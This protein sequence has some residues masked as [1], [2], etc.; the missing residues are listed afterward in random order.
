MLS[1]L[2]VKKPMTVFVAVVLIIVLG[3]VSYMNMT[4]DLLPDFEM[5]YVVIMTTYPGQS[6]EAVEKTVTKPLEASMST[7]ENISNVTS[8]SAEN[9]SMLMLEFEDGT[10]MDSVTVDIRGKID[11]LKGSWPDEVGTPSLL[12]INP[13]IMPVAVAAVNYE[14]KSRAELSYYLENTLQNKLEGINGVASINAMGVLEE[15]ENVVISQEKLDKLNKKIED[16]LNDK[17]GEAE[18]KLNEAKQTLAD[19]IEKAESGAGQIDDAKNALSE[20]QQEVS[21][22]LANA[23]GEL[24]SKQMELLQTKL[25]LLNKEET[26]LSQKQQLQTVYEQLVKLSDSYNKLSEQKEQLTE[27]SA[28]LNMLNEQYQKLVDELAKYEPGTEDYNR[29]VSQL[30][31]IDQKLK[32]FGFT[33]AELPQRAAEA[34]ASLDKVVNSIETIKS[35]IQSMGYS[36]DTFFNET[37]PQMKDSIDKIDEGVA[38]IEDGL[39]QLES[40]EATVSSAIS[41][42][43]AQESAANFQINTAM[44][45]IISN[46]ATLNM[47]LTQLDSAQ[48]EIDT[49]M[50]ELQT[51]K[52]QAKEAADVNKTVTMDNISKILSAQNFSMPAG[53]ITDDNNQK[54]MVR[55]GDTVKDE[56]ELND[57]VLIDIGLD[58]IDPIKVSDVADVFVVDNS[59]EIYAKING[60]NGLL[61]SF[62]KQSNYATAEV[63]D[64]ILAKFEELEKEN[65]GL[66]FTTLMNQ[67][68]YIYMITNSVLQNLLYGALLAIIILFLFLRDIK[69]TVVIACSIPISV[70]FAIVLMYFSGVTLNMI[71]LS[72]LAI[73]VGMLVDNSVVVIENIYRLRN[74]GIPP[75]KAAMNGAKQ[76]A[77]AITA[78]TLTTVCVFLPIVFVEGLTRQLF[79]DMALTIGYSLLASLI[80]ALTLVPAMGQRLFKNTKPRSHKIFDKLITYYEKSLRFTLRHRAIALIVA[81]V[82]LAGSMM[83]SFSKGFSFLPD[84]SSSEISISADLPA[85]NTFEDTA[86]VAQ[87]ME[88][89]LQNDFDCFDTVGVLVGN[90]SSIIGMSSG[91]TDTSSITAYCVLKESEAKNSLNIIKQVQ[92]KLDT[93]DCEVEVGGSSSMSSIGSL[94]GSGV[95][96]KLYGDDLDTLKTT[97]QDMADKLSEIEG[98]DTVDSGIEATTPEIKITVDKEKAVLKNL[99]VAQVY[100][101]VAA[102]LSTEKTATGLTNDNGSDLDV[103]VVDTTE[104]SK[105]IDDIKNIKITYTTTEGDE[106][107]VK[108]SEI[109]DITT[110]ESMNSIKHDN[111]VRYVT[112]SG[113]IKDGYTTTAVTNQVEKYFNSYDL[114]NGFSIEYAGE[115]S[116]TMEAL[117]QLMLMMLLGVIMIY[118][119][120]V[121]QFQSLKSPFIVMFTI[122]LA[123]TG[124]FLGLIVTGY[125]VSVV[126]M[127]GFIMLFGIIVNNG[128]VLVD[129]VNQLRL[130]GMEK[131]QALIDAG[132]TRMRPILMTALTTVFGLLISALGTGTGT[133]MIQP[134]AIVCIGGLLYG[135]LMTLYIVP[136]LYDL[137]NKKPLRKV[138]AEDLEEI[139]D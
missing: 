20:K 87:E 29:V 78:S 122:P 58:G 36:L 89:I 56:E 18:D 83:L 135:T 44:S 63:S 14:G 27:K 19:N 17:F 55:V 107:S 91:S 103:V 75:I 25:E 90:L 67:G 99:T 34:K 45:E 100:Q 94:T 42:L 40:G 97:A 71:S 72:G 126:A 108:L 80:V 84:M 7:L 13:N 106:K 117:Q 30:E 70:I 38:A 53:Y 138:S 39:K 23:S 139:D 132:K 129:Y 47:T 46:E 74:M 114:P 110:A 76:V 6:P 109:S 4:P 32:D 52:E 3:I 57:L 24:N 16:A 50:D 102:A 127:L 104:E 33:K 61:I 49:S 113:T 136:V 37:V 111:Q 92:E 11:T 79:T 28:F 85:D 121:A 96:I 81:V 130:D 60:D 9:Y 124:G 128:I 68:E 115:N 93:L 1:K 35:T 66:E 137:F 73:G 69:P 54:Y 125:D 119:I 112:V 98:I 31:E 123:C 134:L 5:P 88:E 116:T 62:T 10:N 15:S 43:S 101:Q 41:Q 120:M 77:G 82:I 118:L 105:N 26:L 133:E 21:N 51:K 2:S 64:N 48:E 95:S 22:Q 8:T 131:R 59:D 65:E 86:Q 12:K